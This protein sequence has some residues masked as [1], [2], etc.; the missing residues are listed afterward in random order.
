MRTAL[1]IFFA[2]LSVVAFADEPKYRGK[3][4]G[5]WE[6][7]LD[8]AVGEEREDALNGVFW[9]ATRANPAARTSLPADTLK[10]L[11]DMLRNDPHEGCRMYIAGAFNGTIRR[12]QFAVPELHAALL[13]ACADPS[14]HVRANAINSLRYGPKSSKVVS[15]LANLLDDPD[16]SVR[17]NAVM[18][19][20]DQGEKG[21]GYCKTI[22]AMLTNTH[23]DLV[24]I[25][26]ASA[27]WRLERDQTEVLHT[28]IDVWANGTE[29]LRRE[30]V[31]NVAATMGD[32]A[33]PLAP[34]IVAEL[35]FLERFAADGGP[36]DKRHAG[37]VRAQLLPALQ[38]IDQPSSIKELPDAPKPPDGFPKFKV[39]EIDTGLKIGYAVI[40]SDIDGD[41][42][43]DIVVVDQHKVVWYQNP[44]WKKR[45]ILDGRTKADNVCITALD[46]D[47]DKLPE[48]VLGAGWKPADT[49]TPGTLQWLKRAKSLD[50]EWSMHEI[51][52]DEPTVH[53]VRA[54]DLD[55]DGK[56][57]VV[58][59][60]L[61]GR[62]CTAKGNWTD[63]R[64]V[65]ILAYKVPAK[66]PEKKE[67][68][69][70]EVISEEL[71]VVHNFS[72]YTV[73][74]DKSPM[75]VITA[76]YEG[77][78][79][80]ILGKGGHKHATKL[81]HEGNQVNKAGSRGASEIRSGSVNPDPRP[82]NKADG[83]VV[84]T[85][86][87]WHGN[88]VVVYTGAV[89]DKPTRAVVDDQLRWGHAVTFADLDGDRV[90]EL[91]VGVR[92]N[93][94]PKQGDKFTEKRGVRSYRF[95]EKAKKWERYILEDGGVAVEDLTVAD[96]NGDGKPD[97]VAV[98]RATGNARIY[99]NQGK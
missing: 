56:L 63:G 47:G 68:W 23:T 77:Y 31:V 96:L 51:P 74:G 98:G 65:K 66:D 55:G 14:A 38:A 50:D 22:R 80:I 78:S 12:D 67:S 2:T 27:I 30:L 5:E 11:A 10:K 57:E 26:A 91:V 85:I 75:S 8:S 72:P 76:S 7:Q 21:A 93:P 95:D 87:P 62:D 48:L 69:K 13:A 58:M 4:V 24:R 97:I 34:L 29:L 82:L 89:G 40:T 53:R 52:C 33:K 36:D 1:S 90:E 61:Q 46:I 37:Q 19:L 59:A 16:E 28:L 70:P 81:V 45:V 99:W 3:T 60:P 88:S 25:R 92:D 73:P 71:H 43:P 64:P 54:I 79:A 6:K 17:G 15:T 32:A 86:E 41:K 42:K 44:S 20:G 49:K 39:Q 18:A 83:A 84:A 35:R 9:T 94:D